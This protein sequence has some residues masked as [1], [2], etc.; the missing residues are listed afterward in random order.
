MA[1]DQTIAR[2]SNEYRRDILQRPYHQSAIFCLLRSTSY[3]LLLERTIFYFVAAHHRVT[4][5]FWYAFSRFQHIL[6]FFS[7]K[8]SAFRYHAAFKTISIA[9]AAPRFIARYSLPTCWNIDIRVIDGGA[10]RCAST[11]RRRRLFLTIAAQTTT[12]LFAMPRL[13]SCATDI[14]RPRHADRVLRTWGSFSFLATY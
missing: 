11:P 5:I 13:R 14:H 3:S 12:A 7:Q 4:E 1:A 9:N 10:R 2:M 8:S 6:F